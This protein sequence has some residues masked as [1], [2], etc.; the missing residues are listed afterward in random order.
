MVE[1]AAQHGGLEIA[2]IEEMPDA[3]SGHR[4]IGDGGSHAAAPA[5]HA[6]RRRWHAAS[7]RLPTSPRSFSG[8]VSGGIRRTVLSLARPPSRF[9]ARLAAAQPLETGVHSP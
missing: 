9:A 4:D 6:A 1:D 5:L 3:G 7:R 8:M 2:E